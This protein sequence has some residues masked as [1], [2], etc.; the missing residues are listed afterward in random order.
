MQVPL[1]PQQ[2]DA[3]AAHPGEPLAVVDEFGNAAG[4]YL[5]PA[6]AFLHLQS[7]SAENAQQRQNELRRLIEEG[8]ESPDVPAEEAFDRLRKLAK[9]A[10]AGRA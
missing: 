3:I 9:S 6:P 7:L 10:A 4:Y 1:S 8:L 2:R 5:V